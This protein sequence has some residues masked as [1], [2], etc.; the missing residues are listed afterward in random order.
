MICRPAWP[1]V[2]PHWPEAEPAV[3][4]TLLVQEGG[5]LGPSLGNYLRTFLRAFEGSAAGAA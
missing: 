3:L 5:Y 1:R 4:P 2:A